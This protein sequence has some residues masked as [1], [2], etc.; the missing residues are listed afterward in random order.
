LF[1]L[2]KYCHISHNRG[3]ISHIKKCIS[4][5][6]AIKQFVTKTVTNFILNVNY[7]ILREHI[8]NFHLNL[9]KIHDLLHFENFHSF[10]NQEKKYRLPINNYC[11][12]CLCVT[13]HLC[14]VDSSKGWAIYNSN[15]S[16]FTMISIV[17]LFAIL[18]MY[19]F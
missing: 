13:I 7:Q 9:K 6:L 4:S 5:N 17:M 1:L 16:P 14:K 18:R 3:E 2:K 15:E 8:Y 12:Y 19:F 10:W 11:I